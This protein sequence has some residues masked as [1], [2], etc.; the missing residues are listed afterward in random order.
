MTSGWRENT[1]WFRGREEGNRGALRVDS[2]EL[3][4]LSRRQFNCQLPTESS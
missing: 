4:A 1:K 3:S 2:V